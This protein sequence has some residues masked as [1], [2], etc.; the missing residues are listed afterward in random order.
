MERDWGKVAISTNQIIGIKLL[1][2]VALLRAMFAELPVHK[3]RAILRP[4]T[5]EAAFS[6]A[7]PN[8]SASTCRKGRQRSKEG[9]RGQKKATEGEAGRF[10]S[11]ALIELNSRY[12]S[13]MK[14]LCFCV[15]IRML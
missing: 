9:E 1:L 10:G 15:G 8:R 6:L 14:I 4:L 12:A 7:A 13:A 5:S 2:Q 11:S 3:K